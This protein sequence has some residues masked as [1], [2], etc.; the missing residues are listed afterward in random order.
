[1]QVPLGDRARQQARDDLA[2][3]VF[4]KA[5]ED[6]TPRGA[7]KS[8]LGKINQTYMSIVRRNML[9]NVLRVPSYMLQ[10]MLSNSINLG[11]RVSKG[12][13]VDMWTSP[14]ELARITRAQK[15]AAVPGGR[16]STPRS[17]PSCGKSAWVVSRTSP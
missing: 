16:S 9:F 15:A 10:N 13:V 4:N 6:G 11:T 17:T 7:S 14:T 5:L 8:T 1:M 12:A 2:F 3:Q